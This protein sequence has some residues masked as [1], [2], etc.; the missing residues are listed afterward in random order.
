M[1]SGRLAKQSWIARIMPSF[2][3]LR[4]AG[5]LRPTLST[6]PAVSILSSADGS[7]VAAV[8][9]LAMGYCVLSRIVM[10]YNELSGSQCLRA[11]G[12]HPQD[13]EDRPIRPW[14]AGIT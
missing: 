10:F 3:A 11:L 9:A 4:L 7:T 13:R 2:N 5:R 8:A 12:R 1:S 14:S 6:A